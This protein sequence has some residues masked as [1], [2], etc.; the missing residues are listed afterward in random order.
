MHF[1]FLYYLERETASGSSRFGG[2]NLV[3]W[4]L[5]WL[6]L[7]VT[8][9]E[10]GRKGVKRLMAGEDVSASG[11]ASSSTDVPGKGGLRQRMESLETDAADAPPDELPFNFEL[12]KDWV[13][14]E[15]KS[16]Q[17]QRLAA[18][19]MKQGGFG[20][21]HMAGA[22]TSGARPSNMYRSLRALFGAPQDAPE[23]T[24]IEIPT[25]RGRRTAF[26]FIMPH[27]LFAAFY[28]T[29]GRTQTWSQAITGPIG[30]AAQFWQ[31][32]S[33]L[34]FVA[35]HPYLRDR[36]LLAKTIPIGMHA[37]GGAFNKNDNLFTISWNSLLA[38]GPTLHKRFLFTVIKKSDFVADTLDSI[39]RI[40]AW[41]IN[42]LALGENPGKNYVNRNVLCND[43]SLA[44]G[45]RG[46]FC[47]IRG[48]WQFFQEAFYFP[49][50]N[51]GARM[52]WM[53]LASANIAN[54]LFTNSNSDAGWRDTVFTHEAYLDYQHAAGLAIPVLLSLVVGLRLDCF[55]VDTLHAVDLGVCAHVLGNVFWVLAITRRVF[56]GRTQAD[57]VTFLESHIKSWIKRTKC[58]VNLR[59]KL[60]VDRIKTSAG[61]PK[62]RCKGATAR[63]LV[64]YALDLCT[65]FCDPTNAED[66]T[67]TALCSLLARFYEILHNE[68]FW[69]SDAAK[70]E[71]PR[72]GQTFAMLY[73]Q[74]SRQFVTE[75][76]RGWKLTPKHHLWEHLTQHQAPV[77]GNPRFYWCYADEDLVGLMVNL[78]SSVH[79]ITLP[80]SILFKWLHI[81]FPDFFNP[82]LV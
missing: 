50:W 76:R 9:G 66:A 42:L 22:G 2:M 17:V 39:W 61:W 35:L 24:W 74:L 11:G 58:S 8:V 43:P 65:E 48:D 38:D 12:K 62:F 60:T 4:K 51:N 77:F 80:E 69:L 27:E 75:R 7:V 21:E 64:R 14:G 25:T 36:T 55:M 34:D 52:C 30:S 45:W 53:C 44:D 46:I 54:L 72:L 19:H 73:T 31:L 15:L 81:M 13:K 41:S 23:I 63:H 79:P 1:I 3:Y 49:H 18:A 29:R 5:L 67:M 71:I 47:Q 26:P 59:G 57:A 37:D 20:A 33:S 28:R 10:G 6:A 78:A 56:G 32:Q 68:S 16:A 70:A 82:A 40:F